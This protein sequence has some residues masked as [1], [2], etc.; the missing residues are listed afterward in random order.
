M[1]R[2]AY[3]DTSERHIGELG[4]LYHSKRRAGLSGTGSDDE[5]IGIDRIQLPPL[6]TRHTGYSGG[7][8]RSEV[9]C[10]Y[11]LEAVGRREA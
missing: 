7:G 10:F 1:R 5:R 2:R 4:V 9:V 6:Y 3:L 11:P 8:E